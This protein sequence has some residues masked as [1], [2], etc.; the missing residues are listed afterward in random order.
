MDRNTAVKLAQDAIKASNKRLI[1]AVLE[2]DS[3]DHVLDA[4]GSGEPPLLPLGR[5]GQ[6]EDHR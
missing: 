3:V 6:L 1:D 5:L 4:H 2:L